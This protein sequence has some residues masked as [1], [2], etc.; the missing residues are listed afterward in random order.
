ME[1]TPLIAA[2]WRRER[3][4]AQVSSAVAVVPFVGI[5]DSG[6]QDQNNIELPDYLLPATRAE[7]ETEEVERTNICPRHRTQTDR[8]TPSS[9]NVSASG[10]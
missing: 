9:S 8:A 3:V 2:G 5:S 1:Q 10:H 6:N 4:Q 7:C